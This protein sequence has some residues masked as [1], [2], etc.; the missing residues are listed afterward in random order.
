MEAL[1]LVYGLKKKWIHCKWI[2]TPSIHPQ[3]RMCRWGCVCGPLTP[4]QCVVDKED[5]NALTRFGW[6]K[7]QTTFILYFT[8]LSNYAEPRLYFVPTCTC[9]FYNHTYLVLVR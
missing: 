4:A 5:M 3:W 2:S 1:H 6:F 8:P 7:P 9:P